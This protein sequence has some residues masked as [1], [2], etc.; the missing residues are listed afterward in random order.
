MTMK[1]SITARDP[2]RPA[3]DLTSLT[4]SENYKLVV[5]FLQTCSAAQT[6]TEDQFE[7]WSNAGF[8]IE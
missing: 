7:I 8:P 3:W 1:H 6:Q 4:S 5:I 2:N